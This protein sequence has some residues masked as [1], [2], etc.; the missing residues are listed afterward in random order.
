MWPMRLL[1]LNAQVQ[2]LVSN[3]EIVSWY[4]AKGIANGH[5]MNHGGQWKFDFGVAEV[6]KCRS[7][8]CFAGRNVWRKSGRICGERADEGTFYFAGD[9]AL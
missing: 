6:C 2:K 3:Y 5:E 9:T 7:F 8:Q 4:K 1:S